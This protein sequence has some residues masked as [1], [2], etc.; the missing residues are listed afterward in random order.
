MKKSKAIIVT[1]VAI[2]VGVIALYFVSLLWFF[3]YIHNQ[4]L[5]RFSQPLMSIPPPADTQVLDSIIQVGQQSGNS[6]HCDYLAAWL[7][8]TSSTKQD[9]EKYY[10]K[11]YKGG[12]SLNFF[13]I[14]EP[15]KLGIGTVNSTNISTLDYWVDNKSK[16]EGAN[17]I[18]YIFEGAMTSAFDYR[19][20]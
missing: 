6:D 12:S 11:N 20:M 15:H 7:L 3:P 1:V 2:L 13:W 8:K 14:S 18:V 16:S 5:S 10:S 4:D 9:I 19:C 17:L